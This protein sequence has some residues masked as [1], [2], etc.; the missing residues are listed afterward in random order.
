MPVC[1]PEEGHH[2]QLRRRERVAGA[3]RE[4]ADPGA[5]GGPGHG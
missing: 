3:H 5:R 2:R 4:P 1:V